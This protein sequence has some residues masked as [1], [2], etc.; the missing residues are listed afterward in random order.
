MSGCVL[1]IIVVIVINIIVIIIII[2][3]QLNFH[4]KMQTRFQ[5]VLFH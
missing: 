4:H 2:T 3:I 1:Q 5:E